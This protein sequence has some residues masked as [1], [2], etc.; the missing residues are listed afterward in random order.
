MTTFFSIL[1]QVNKIFLQMT[2]N[3]SHQ[4]GLQPVKQPVVTGMV[5]FGKQGNNKMILY[6][7]K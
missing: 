4:P 6:P 3:V 5:P 7:A 2:A 1:Q